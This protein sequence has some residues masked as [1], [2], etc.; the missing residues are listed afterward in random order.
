MGKTIKEDSPKSKK[1]IE[2]E[3]ADYIAR[4]N[5]QFKGTSKEYKGTVSDLLK[6]VNKKK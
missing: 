5:K 3:T 2:K 4:W 6:E 1:Q